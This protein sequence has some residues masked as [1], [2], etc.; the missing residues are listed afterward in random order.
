LVNFLLL[1]LQFLLWFL[2]PRQEEGNHS[3]TPMN[4]DEVGDTRKRRLIL[5][6]GRHGKARKVGRTRN[7]EGKKTVE[8]A[9]RR[10]AQ[11]FADGDTW[12]TGKSIESNVF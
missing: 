4:T 12:K 3:S 6:H 1:R 5:N 7:L 2:N 10:L 9:I 11:I 8:K